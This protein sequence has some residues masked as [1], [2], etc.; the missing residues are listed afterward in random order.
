MIELKCTKQGLEVVR[1]L[2]FTFFGNK[3]GRLNS[4]SDSPAC[5]LLKGGRTNERNKK[6]KN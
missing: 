1:F 3:E 4:S 2:P 5:L 6:K